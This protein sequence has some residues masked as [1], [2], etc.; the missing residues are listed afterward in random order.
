MKSNYENKY[1]E[2][3]SFIIEDSDIIG[4]IER[5]LL[6][7]KRVRYNISSQRAEE[8]ESEFLNEQ[9]LK[10]LTTTEKEYTEEVLFFLEEGNI[11]SKL[12]RKMLVRLKNKLGILDKRAEELETIILNKKK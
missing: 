6:D 3:L 1:L 7:R 9:C 5:N 2:D 4:N 10:G 8:L 12:E 11:I